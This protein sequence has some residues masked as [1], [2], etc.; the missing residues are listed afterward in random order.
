[1]RCLVGQQTW[2]HA[3]VT[4]PHNRRNGAEYSLGFEAVPQARCGRTFFASVVEPD[5][6]GAIGGVLQ[7]DAPPSPFGPSPSKSHMPTYP[8][9]MTSENEPQ[10]NA[11][12]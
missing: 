8:P 7:E 1:M 11:I 2:G 12:V 5:E 10:S 3:L 4:H 6:S 9:D